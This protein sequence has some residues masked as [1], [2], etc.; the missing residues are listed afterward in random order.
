MNGNELDRANGQLGQPPK[1]KKWLWLRILI[2][3]ILGILLA[4]LVFIIYRWWDLKYNSS[5]YPYIPVPKNTVRSH[6]AR[7][8]LAN[9]VLD[10]NETQTEYAVYRRPNGGLL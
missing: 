5:I 7:E 8:L 2:G 4:L 9:L 10:I 3:I 6:S 1:K